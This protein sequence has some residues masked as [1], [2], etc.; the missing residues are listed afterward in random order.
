MM[1]FS[2]K[3][4]HTTGEVNEM[5]DKKDNKETTPRSEQAVKA[6][7]DASSMRNDPQGSYTGKPKDEREVPVQDADDL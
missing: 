2:A 5:P 7:V 1:K 6:F 3:N 4:R